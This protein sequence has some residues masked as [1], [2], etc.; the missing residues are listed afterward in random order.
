[1]F[2]INNSKVCHS[3]SLLI[4]PKINLRTLTNTKELVIIIINCWCW[5]F[6]NRD[7]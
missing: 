7:L 1:M 2:I 4:S 3:L 5:L 6:F